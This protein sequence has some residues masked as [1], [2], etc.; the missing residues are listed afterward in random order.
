[1]SII[2]PRKVLG[3]ARQT[4]PKE[5][6][7]QFHVCVTSPPYWGMRS[8]LPDKHPLKHLEIG[9]EETLDLYIQHLLEVF[10]EVRRVLR[11]DGLLWVNLGDRMTSGG[12]RQ[13][14]RSLRSTSGFN[15][16]AAGVFRPNDPPG[17]KKK[18]LCMLP[19]RVA[20]AMQTDGWYLRSKIPWIKR[21]CQPE[22]AEDRPANA[23]EYVF[24]FAKNEDYYYDRFAVTLKASENTHPRVS[25]KRANDELAGVNPK[26]RNAAIGS[27]QH[28]QWKESMAG[29]VSARNRR[30]TDWFLESFQG[31]LQDDFGEPLALIV[32][33]KGTSIEHFATFPPKLVEP[34]IR[35]STS[36]NGCCAACGAPRI[37]IVED[38]EPDREHQRACG[39]DA[40]GE[41][42]GQAT[43]D[44]KAAKVA[45]GSD[46]KRRILAGMVEKK[47][48]GWKAGCS[49]PEQRPVPCRVLD[50][51]HGSGTTAEVSTG[52][53][54]DYLGC[55]LNDEYFKIDSRDSQTAMHLV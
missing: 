13:Y 25:M 22:S 19:E 41:Y 3:D 23:L 4:L 15:N 12:R 43:K 27:K 29:M 31:L 8:Y 10:R 11:D 32:N 53:G 48:V 34:M 2:V 26:A 50:P 44:Y 21:N 39:A 17:L 45:G 49:C 42:H 55:E 14:D 36:E 16:R 38:G 30:N 24:M 28:A 9:C 18:E 37:R 20:M 54:R 40:Q 7:K 33:P 47:T 52:L 5:R 35:A 1:M 46:L 51:F 6:E